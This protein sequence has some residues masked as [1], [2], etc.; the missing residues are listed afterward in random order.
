MKNRL[1]AWFR[2]DLPKESALSCMRLLSR[3]R[4]N[5]VC[6]EAHCP[7]MGSCFNSRQLTLMILGDSCTRNCAFCAV[8]KAGRKALCLDRDEPERIASLVKSLGLSYAVIT[9]VSRDDLADYGAGH[10]AQ[11]VESIRRVNP[12]IGIEL[13]IPDF[14]GNAVSIR[15]VVES[16]PSVIGHN[17]ET[18]ARLY[19]ALRPQAEYRLSLEVL[20]KIKELAPGLLTKSSLMLGLGEK[21]EEVAEA[22]QDLRQSRCD[23]LTLGQY[24]APSQK[25]YP[26]REFIAPEQFQRYAELGFRLGFK[27]VLSGPKVRSSYQADKLFREASH[28]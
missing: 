16:G 14:R 10:F 3:R 27:A 15:R 24:L 26:V 13:L 18:V 12:G 19:P 4:I 25:H 22:M 2:Q 5:T 1:P 6:K 11:S 7:N 8:E 17:L 21:K 20:K 23:M 28:V 9:S